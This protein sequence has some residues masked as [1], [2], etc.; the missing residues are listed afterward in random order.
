MGTGIVS[1]ALL[2]AGY[3]GFSRALLGLAALAWVVLLTVAVFCLARDRPRFLL[4]ARSPSGLTGVA[5]TAVLASRLGTFGWTG[6]AVALLIIGLI[7]WVVLMALLVP[8]L[9]RRGP[10]QIFMLTVAAEALAS[11]SASLA[12]GQRASWLIYLALA[13]AGIGLLAYPVA[14][15]RF[16]FSE[17]VR[18]AGDQWVAG[19]SLA[20]SALAVAQ[21]ATAAERLSTPAGAA[22]VLE[23]VALAIWIVSALWIVPLLVGELMPPRARYST[24]R[25]ATVF[26]LG[27]Y[28]ASAFSVAAVAGVSGLDSFARVWMWL[29]VA[30]WAL[31]GAGLAHSGFGWL[32]RPRASP[33]PAPSPPH[34]LRR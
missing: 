14:L 8:R 21:V 10:G 5:G 4:E 26:P 16:R 13:L 12:A 9:P 32:I 7:S 2:R 29:A 28:C 31:A 27:M 19:G 6:V 18:G 3:S 17:L 23:D 30:V 20:I 22:P 15:V 11:L 25:W 1:V 33:V 24:K 34:H